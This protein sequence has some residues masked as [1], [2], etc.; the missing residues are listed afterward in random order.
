M[1]CADK[2]EQIELQELP[3]STGNMLPDSTADFKG[4]HF[5]PY[6]NESKLFWSQKQG[7][8]HYY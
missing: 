7:E 6:I 2:E 3:G 4:F 5:N 8:M 1:R